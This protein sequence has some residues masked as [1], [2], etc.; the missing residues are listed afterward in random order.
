MAGW[1]GLDDVIPPF[2]AVGSAIDI[3]KHLNRVL[4]A[5]LPDDVQATIGASC[6]LLGV[7]YAGHQLCV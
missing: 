3:N 5:V 6:G 2:F 7:S 1:S 4:H